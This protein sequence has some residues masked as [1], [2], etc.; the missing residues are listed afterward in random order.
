MKPWRAVGLDRGLKRRDIDPVVIV[1]RN[2][3]ERLAAE[4]GDFHRL[5]DA[6]M[7][8]GGGIG[9]EPLAAPEP[10]APH[11][12][13]QRRG[14]RDE[15]ADEVR[16][17]GA[18]DE[19]AAGAVGKTEQLAHP[20]GDLPLHLDGNVIAAAEIG[21]EAGGQHLRQ[22]ADGIAAAMNPAHEA[23]DA[24][25]RW[26]RAARAH[27]LVMHVCQRGGLGGNLGAK[28]GAHIVGDRLPDRALADVLDIVEDVIKHPV[29]IRAEAR[30][31]GGIEGGRGLRRRG[32]SHG[33]AGSHWLVN[34]HL[35]PRFERQKA[36][37]IGP[38]PS[39]PL[40]TP[41]T[42][43]T[44]PARANLGGQH[45]TRRRFRRNSGARSSWR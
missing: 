1:D 10:L 18:G 34:R 28:T 41:G 30:P 21:V 7:G 15:H 27:E 4:T 38:F 12:G 17:R 5:G 29:S 33:S 23:R 8:G 40:T 32:L 42:S 20:L 11:A 36:R 19:K 45:G 16:H 3:P 25:C 2:D 31:V 22:H 26:H 39:P 43:P 6:A 44:I 13:A 35:R 9:D 37:L 24:R 14:A